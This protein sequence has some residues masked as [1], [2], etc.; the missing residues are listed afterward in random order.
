MRFL[1]QIVIHVSLLK[2]AETN[3]L[4]KVSIMVET[5]KNIQICRMNIQIETCQVKVKLRIIQGFHIKP[6][7]LF[8]HDFTISIHN[9]SKPLIRKT[10]KIVI[11]KG[12]TRFF[13]KILDLT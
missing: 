13:Q 11:Y 8:S 12:K 4:L 9:H 1:D 5:N 10:R 6:R 2:V 7:C 3:S